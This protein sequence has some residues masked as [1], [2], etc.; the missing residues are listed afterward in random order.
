MSPIDQTR[1]DAE[2]AVL[3]LLELILP[4]SSDLWTFEETCMSALMA[5]GRHL[6]KLQLEALSPTTPVVEDGTTTWRVAVASRFPVMTTFGGITV[7]RPLFRAVRNGPTRCFVAERT[8]LVAGFWTEK[9]A[10]LGSL[11]VSEMPMAR[12]EQFFAEAGTMTVSSTSLLRLAGHVSGLWEENRQEHEEEVRQAQEIPPEATA[13]AVSLD[14]VMIATVDSDKA[15][16]K[17]EARERGQADKGPAGWREAS[18]GV[19][20]FYDKDG[21]RLATRRYARMPEEDKAT[22]KSWLR[23][24]LVHLRTAR[25]DLKVLAIADGAANNWSFLS[26]LGADHELVDFYHTAEHLHRHVS[27]A[28]G[29]STIDTQ[30]KLRAMR[31][32]L[33]DEPGAAAKVFKDFQQLREEAGTQAVSTTKKKGKRQPTY[34]ERHHVRMDYPGLRALHLPIGSGVTESTCKLVVCDRFRRTGM[35]WSDPGGQAVMTLRAAQ[36]SST[37]DSMWGLLRKLNRASLRPPSQPRSAA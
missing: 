8:P 15:A 3:K 4:P 12:A 9:A 30:D 16:K 22:T 27:K 17:A 21:E 20:A 6:M 35:R 36:V 24:E 11:A 29:A 33:R 2:A 34:F 31:R 25:P 13:A 37:F 5:A 28:N 10:K 26:S 19:L 18:V 7:E 14:G 23:N 32:A 1:K